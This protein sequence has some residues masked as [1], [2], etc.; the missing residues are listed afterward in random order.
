MTPEV[1]SYRQAR[2]LV[3]EGEGRY[4]MDVAYGTDENDKPVT[5][6]KLVYVNPQSNEE[7]TVQNEQK[8]TAAISHYGTHRTKPIY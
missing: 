7:L 2:K 8:Y 6:W 3:S 5:S 1:K 4:K